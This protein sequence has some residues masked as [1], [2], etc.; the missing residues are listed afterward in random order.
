MHCANDATPISLRYSA[1][2]P[3]KQNQEF[4]TESIESVAYLTVILSPSLVYTYSSL[5][6]TGDV[7]VS[8]KQWEYK[9]EQ[10]FQKSR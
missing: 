4:S 7:F 6:L 3:Q 8:H 1:L 2:I 9:T 5:L 10:F